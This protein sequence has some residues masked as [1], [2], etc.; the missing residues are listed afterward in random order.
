L[1]KKDNNRFVLSAGTIED[2]FGPLSPGL[3]YHYVN[4]GQWSL[5]DLLTHALQFSGPAQVMV[6]S[7]SLSET[8]IRSFVHLMDSGL[9][10]RLDCLFDISTKRNKLELLMFA[11]NVSSKV[12]ISS[13]HAKF[14]AI[15][16]PDVCVCINT[17][18]NLTVN[19]RHE[20][21]V[22]VTDKDA[23]LEYFKFIDAM[24]DSAIHLDLEND[25]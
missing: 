25:S 15:K 16:T 23:A 24:F 22:L 14:I 20:A 1:K 17:S 19:R 10:T 9:I 7:F 21:G 13:N 11:Q 3:F 4:S 8:A 18:A 12:Y 2:D 5:H 6:T